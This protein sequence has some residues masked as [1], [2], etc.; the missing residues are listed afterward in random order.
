MV[1]ATVKKLSCKGTILR[2]ERVRP[3]GMRTATACP[4][5][6]RLVTAIV[7]VNGVEREMTFVTNNTVW[8]ARTIAELYRVRWQIGVPRQGHIIQSVEDQPRPRDSGLVAWEAPWRESKTAEPSDNLL[9]KDYARRTRWQRPVNADVASLHAS[10]V[11][12]TVDHA[13]TGSSIARGRRRPCIV[14][15]GR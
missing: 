6:L 11:A 3:A 10:P 1:F 2:D 7:E 4:G 12:E 15:Q 13:C 5:L 8:R 9:R 14:D